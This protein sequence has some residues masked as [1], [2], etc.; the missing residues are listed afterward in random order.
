VGVVDPSSGVQFSTRHRASL[1]PGTLVF[2]NSRIEIK[3]R[4]KFVSRGGEKLEAALKHWSI[5]VEGKVCLDAGCSTG[6]FT[7]CLLKNGAARVCAVD[8]GYGQIEP[9]LRSDPRVS[10]FEK[11]HILRW[12]P[13]W[14]KPP[15]FV[16]IDL[17]FISLKRV[18]MKIAAIAGKNAGILA[19]VKPQ[20][21]VDPRFARKG[22]VRN[23][24]IQ[25]EAVKR[26]ASYSRR[27]GLR[28]VGE[29]P[30]PLLGAKGNREYWLFLNKGMTN[31]H[32][33]T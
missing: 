21:E 14:D 16:T 24:S 4:Q 5:S 7:D 9:R 1:K 17:S 22:V 11:T 19:L 26:I 2:E 33:N 6:G 27:L 20:F 29:F 3:P 18:L 25:I 28:V 13:A 8:V 23:R 15:D 32:Q 30:C 31:D 12:V 10:L